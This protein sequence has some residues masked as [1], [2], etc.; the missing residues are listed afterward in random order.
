MQERRD[1]V[2]VFTHTHRGTRVLTQTLMC[3][4]IEKNVSSPFSLFW[5]LSQL[6][7]FANSFSTKELD[8]E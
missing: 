6:F 3:V 1:G 2:L 8:G 7:N 5:P 4:Q